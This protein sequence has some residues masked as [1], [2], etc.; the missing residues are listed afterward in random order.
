VDFCC[1][2]R[3]L[4]IELDGEQHAETSGYD[5]RRTEALAGRGFRVLRFWNNEV[6][7]NL[8]G[9]LERIWEELQ[10]PPP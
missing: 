9:V 3:R 4:I 1:V 2:E 8:D 10:A 5:A 7:E 6:L